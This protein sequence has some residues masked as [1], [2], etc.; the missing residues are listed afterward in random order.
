MYSACCSRETGFSR[1]VLQSWDSQSLTA[2]LYPQ[3]EMLL[4][5]SVHTVTVTLVEGWHW[6]SSFFSFCCIETHLFSCFFFTRGVLESSPQKGWT[7]THSLVCAYLPKVAVSKFSQP[8][9]GGV[10]QVCWF[11][12]PYHGLSAYFQMHMWERLL[13]GLLTCCCWVSQVPQEHFY[14]WV[15]NYLLNIGGQKVGMSY[16][17]MMLIS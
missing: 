12:S 5:D 4:P 10:W 7:F 3:Q 11:R 9:L 1:I 15:P 2:L 14:G 17:A 13:L 8:W 6:Q 16:T